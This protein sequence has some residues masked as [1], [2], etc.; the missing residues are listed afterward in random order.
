MPMPLEKRNMRAKPFESLRRPCYLL[1]IALRLAQFP[2]T[3]VL[4]QHDISDATRQS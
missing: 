4:T 3:T 2:T 1:P